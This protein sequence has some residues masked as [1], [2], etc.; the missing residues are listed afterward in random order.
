MQ[1]DPQLESESKYTK[2]MRSVAD[3]TMDAIKQVKRNQKAVVRNRGKEYKDHFKNIP[4]P[5]PLF[6]S[7]KMEKVEKAGKRGSGK[8][9]KKSQSLMSTAESVQGKKVKEERIKI[10]RDNLIKQHPTFG[11]TGPKALNFAQSI[12]DMQS[13]TTEGGQSRTSSEVREGVICA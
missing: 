1:G 11:E 8:E 6:K 5:K 4:K 10:N 9:E 2:D 13:S 7:L 12:T 3:Q